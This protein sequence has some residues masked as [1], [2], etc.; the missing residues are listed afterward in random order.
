MIADHLSRA[1]LHVHSKH[2]D[3][4]SE[5][6]LRRIGAPES[7]V[8]PG[9]LYTACRERGMDFVTITDHNSI[10]GA[11]E[12]ADRPGTFLSAELTTYFPEDGCKIHCLAL[13]IT[14]AQFA[15]LQQARQ[16][17]YELREVLLHHDIIHAIAHPL[18]RVNE[19]LTIEH[20][21][22]LIL[23]FNRFEG[24][25]GSR[26]PRAGDLARVILGALTPE[27]IAR[28]ADRH[29]IEPT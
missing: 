1:D 25:N 16:N 14:E 29:G 23:L 13:G 19:K 18:F 5:W 22:K 7:F 2:S 21:E 17:I 26:D 27:D 6:F 28:L 3:R 20:F 10:G 15:E 8:E 24:I 4:P 12:I 11:L 9:E